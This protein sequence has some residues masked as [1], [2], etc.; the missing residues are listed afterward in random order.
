MFVYAK[1]NKVYEHVV[2]QI[3]MAI[4]DGSLKPGDKLP[5]EKELID[6]FRVSR[7]TLREALRSLESTGVLEI[8]KGASGGPFIT[9]IGMDRA[10]ENFIDFFR[11][12]KLLLEHLVEVRMMLEPPMAAKVALIIKPEG[13]ERLR[14]SMERCSHAIKT[15]T[16]ESLR[17]SFLEFHRIIADIT[18]NPILTFLLDVIKTLPVSGLDPGKQLTRKLAQEILEDHVRIYETLSEGSSERTSEAMR[19]HILGLENRL[20]ARNKGRSSRKQLEK[21]KVELPD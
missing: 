16:M 18:E 4:C 6:K 7:G 21:E 17:E 13:L 1:S 20:L 11:F 3:R 5:S 19:R 2:E 8:R 14:E 9:E 12:K 15:K 10:K